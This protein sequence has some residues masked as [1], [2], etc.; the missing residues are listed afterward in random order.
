MVHVHQ[1]TSLTLIL[2][3][4]FGGFFTWTEEVL[5]NT[6]ISVL[7]EAII[8]HTPHRPM[9]P[10]LNTSHPLSAKQHYCKGV[11]SKVEFSEPFCRFFRETWIYLD[12]YCT[13]PKIVTNMAFCK[14]NILSVHSKPISTM[15]M[16]GGRLTLEQGSQITILWIRST[17]G[18]TL[19]KVVN[20]LQG[21]LWCSPFL[22]ATN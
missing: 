4:I 7:A 21:Q 18:M 22:T 11:I 5:C 10:W 6:N 13:F 1:N 3:D 17:A 20:T 16:N 19:K 2:I 9:L 15:S 12:I 14:I 8:I